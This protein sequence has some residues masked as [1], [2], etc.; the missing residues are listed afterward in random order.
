M[1]MSNN[2]R[3]MM[4]L[5]A[6]IS[7]KDR[8]ESQ[9]GV[10]VGTQDRYGHGTTN[11]ANPSGWSQLYASLPCWVFQ[12]R[13]TRI[14]SGER[15]VSDET[16]VIAVPLST[17]LQEGDRVDQV[18]DRM[19]NMLY[20]PLQVKHVTHHVRYIDADLLEVDRGSN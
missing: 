5:R 1:S 13:G 7:R 19:G 8:L 16:S 2:S 15:T 17:D 4:R 3:G 18:C 6:T 12:Q 9:D 11:P 14:I 20:G 10:M